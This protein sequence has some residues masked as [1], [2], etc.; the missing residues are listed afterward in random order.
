MV[1]LIDSTHILTFYLFKF[2]SMLQILCYILS[3]DRSSE[4]RTN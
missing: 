4:K 2:V 1:M 3:I